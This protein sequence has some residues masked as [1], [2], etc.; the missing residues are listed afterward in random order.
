MS[1]YVLY[2]MPSFDL[3]IP[4]VSVMGVCLVLSALEKVVLVLDAPDAPR[5][6]EQFFEALARLREFGEGGSVAAATFLGELLAFPGPAHDPGE[7]Y[8]WYYIGLS[9]SSYSVEFEDKNNT[10]PHYCRPVGNFRNELMV[11][12]LVLELGFEKIH[13]L[14]VEAEAW[15]AENRDRW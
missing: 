9:Q 10:P 15:L 1:T 13:E 14:D 5:E 6:G 8:K 7:V 3:A 2:V 12:E 4:L 11:S